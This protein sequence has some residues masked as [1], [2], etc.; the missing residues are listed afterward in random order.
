MSTLGL[1]YGRPTCYV[2]TSLSTAHA[3]ILRALYRFQAAI[4]AI[5]ASG[6]NNARNYVHSQ[7][8]KCTKG[9]PDGPLLYAGHSSRIGA[10]ITASQAGL[11]DSTIPTLGRALFV[12][13][14]TI[15]AVEDWKRVYDAGSGYYVRI[16]SLRGP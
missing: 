11:P 2:A 16:S 12:L 8:E 6:T 9:D 15:A 1:R 5:V 4:A 10:A 14:A 13:Q 3:H 7:I